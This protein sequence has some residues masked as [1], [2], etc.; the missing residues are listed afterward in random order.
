MTVAGLRG[1]NWSAFEER[2]PEQL[3]AAIRDYLGS[4]PVTGI[5]TVESQR[6]LAPY[7]ALAALV[8]AVLLVLP[9]F[10]AAIPRRAQPPDQAVSG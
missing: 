8:L 1:A 6:N 4:G 2:Q 5:G 3:V 7:T 9:A 10:S